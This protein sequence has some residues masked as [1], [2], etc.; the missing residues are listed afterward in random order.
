MSNVIYYSLWQPIHSHHNCNYI[1]ISV[2]I[3]IMIQCIWSQVDL[4]GIYI[5]VTLMRCNHLMLMF[6]YEYIFSYFS[7]VFD[8]LII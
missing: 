7:Y 8:T 5:S 2:V 1:I 4:H 6:C 3:Y